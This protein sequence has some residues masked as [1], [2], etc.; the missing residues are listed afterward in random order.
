MDKASKMTYIDLQ[1]LITVSRGDSSHM[2]KYLNQFK[3]LIPERS[4]QLKEALETNDR[5][6][7]RQLLHKMSPQLQFFGIQNIVIP[8]Q[9]LEFEYMSMPLDEMEVIVKDIIH[10]LEG[11]II[12]VNKTIENQLE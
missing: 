6:L 10:K 7:T 5:K 1:N 3:E 12:E 2:L 9:R 11:A 4:A 8:I